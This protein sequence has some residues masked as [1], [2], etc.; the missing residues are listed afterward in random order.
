MQNDTSAFGRL[1]VT[2]RLLW[3]SSSLSG[4]Y[5]LGGWYRPEADLDDVEH[6]TL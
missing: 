1:L 6:V 4:V 3:V 2:Q 5:H